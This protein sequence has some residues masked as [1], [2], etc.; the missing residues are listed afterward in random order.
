MK[1]YKETP[2][3]DAGLLAAAQAVERNLPL[4]HAEDMGARTRPRRVSRTAQ[5]DSARRLTKR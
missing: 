2:A 4:R 5:S 1:E 3:L